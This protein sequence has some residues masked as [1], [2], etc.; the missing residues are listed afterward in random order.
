M[1]IRCGPGE[2]I[3][4]TSKSYLSVCHAAA[5]AK[6][7]YI[8]AY[9]KYYYPTEFYTSALEFS[10]IK[11]YPALITE[12]KSLGI[13]VHGPDVEISENNFTGKNNEIYFGFSG[14]KG[15][16]NISKS[17]KPFTMFADYIIDT[18]LPEG[19]VSKL[20]QAGAFDRKIKNRTALLA[21]LSDY[22]KE[23]SIIEK[24]KASL[25]QISAMI[26]DLENGKEL[27]RNKYK[28]KTKKLPD[29][30]KLLET[31]Q[32]ALDKIQEATTNIRHIVIPCEQIVDDIDQNLEKEKELLGMYASGHPLDQYGTPKDFD[33]T[34]IDDLDISEKGE[35][36]FIFG[37]ISDFVIRTQKKD[38]RSMCT[39]TLNDQT[40]SIECCCFANS[41]ELCGKE[42]KEGAIVKLNGQNKV[43]NGSDIDNP[44]YQFILANKP[45]AAVRVFD[46]KDTY[47]VNINGL[48]EW[49]A[50]QAIALQFAQISGH[51]LFVYDTDTGAIY[52][53]TLRVSEAIVKKLNI[54]IA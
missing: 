41:Y 19:T 30:K 53:T 39:F 22:Y 8:T 28:I 26:S 38:G 5:Y 35:Y 48:E 11:K 9:L 31:K 27:D 36:P 7:S 21:V 25:D 2:K 15:L 3:E 17:S 18:E 45:S 40:G 46:K 54:K 14:I 13:T 29:K 24:S 20:I 50:T 37:K 42:L 12:A 47:Y 44:T 49:P 52:R 16:G 6:V 33:C 4:I 10:D 1:H 23:K 34:A 32:A 51:P 43:K